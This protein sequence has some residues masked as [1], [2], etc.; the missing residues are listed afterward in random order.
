MDRS[1]LARARRGLLGLLGMTLAGCALAPPRS[2]SGFAPALA[3]ALPHVVGVYA[4]ERAERADFD[5]AGTT[6]EA[7]RGAGAQPQA[8][9]GA[10][11]FV[12]AGTLLVT[13][14]HVVAQAEPLVVKLADQRVLPAELVG[15]D[16]DTDIALLRIA[17]QALPAPPLGRSAELRPGHWVLAVGEPYGLYRSVTA[18][19]VGGTD[20]HFADDPE[21]PFIQTDL[22]LNPGN[23]GGP[24]LDAA[25]RV[26][27]MNLRTVVG[28]YGA[29]GVSLAIPVEIV[30]EVA[31]ELQRHGRV[32]RLHLGADFADLTAP[33]ALQLGRPDT[34][35]ALVLAVQ[36]GSLAERMDLRAGD[37]VLA[38]GERGVARSADLARQLLGWRRA[39][40]TRITVLR[41]GQR[42]E[43]RL[44]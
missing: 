15:S 11:F 24:L 3:S 44:P 27:G 5:P 35:G 6:A 36:P 42:R 18:G 28:A 40:G 30:L 32:Q 34:A 41:E 25:G 1:F 13:A 33:L 12:D 21:L 22:P 14:A 23:S 29:P 31:G 20:R 7:E 17:P 10:G 43:L 26:V 9:I 38:M 4:L 16:P 39:E 37:L 8:R 19:I 2:D